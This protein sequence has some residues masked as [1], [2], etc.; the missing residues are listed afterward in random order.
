MRLWP[1][2]MTQFNEGKGNK[3]SEQLKSLSFKIQEATSKN[4]PMTEKKGKQYARKIIYTNQEN[5]AIK[6]I[7]VINVTDKPVILCDVPVVE[8]FVLDCK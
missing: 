1:N 4:V 7:P 2:L 8:N 5:L 6:L 3:E